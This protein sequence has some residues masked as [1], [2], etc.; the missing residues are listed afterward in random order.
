MRPERDDTETR[1]P[2]GLGKG[3]VCGVVEVVLGEYLP[4]PT[5]REEVALPPGQKACKSRRT[6]CTSPGLNV[7]GYVHGIGAAAGNSDHAGLLGPIQR[8]FISLSHIHPRHAP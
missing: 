8:N 7:L 4:K 2:R 5:Q 3:G 6:P 1:G